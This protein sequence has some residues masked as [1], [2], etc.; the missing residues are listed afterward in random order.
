MEAEIS[1]GT[2]VFTNEYSVVIQ[3]KLIFVSTN[4]LDLSLA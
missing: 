1:T 4:W 3:N 2:S